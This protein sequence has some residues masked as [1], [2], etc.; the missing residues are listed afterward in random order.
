MATCKIFDTLA[1]DDYD[2][3]KYVF[4]QKGNSG[5]TNTCCRR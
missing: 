2:I 3:S 5:G 4:N 1:A